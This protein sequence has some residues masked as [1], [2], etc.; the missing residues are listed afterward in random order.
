MSGPTR[1]EQRARL[2]Q[3]RDAHGVAA[4]WRSIGASV[5]VV[6]QSAIVC[7]LCLRL[8]PRMVGVGRGLSGAP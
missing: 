2:L 1:L 5:H 8:R 3:R 4:I 7:G 6:G